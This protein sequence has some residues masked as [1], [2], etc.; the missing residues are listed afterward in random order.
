M[1]G[2]QRPTSRPA[3][4]QQQRIVQMA[5]MPY[6]RYEMFRRFSFNVELAGCTNTSG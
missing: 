4:G 3:L 5:V 2:G 6:G 1:S